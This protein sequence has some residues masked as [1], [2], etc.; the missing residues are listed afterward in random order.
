MLN[1]SFIKSYVNLG[2]AQL[3]QSNER[4]M[5]GQSPYI[6]NA[7]IFYQSKKHDF[8]A[9][10][11]YNVIGQRIVI[12]GFDAYPDIY[13]MPRNLLDVNF[14]KKIKE[15]VE[16]KLS[17]GDILNQ[18]FVLL[19]DANQNGKFERKDDQIIQRYRPGMT[20]SFGIGVKI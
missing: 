5:Q 1:A 19:Q 16:L 18:D 14:S 17:F 20:I 10:I 8:Q 3:G 15:N 13:E 12:I 4:P 7:G 6:V 11:L 9:N 2:Q